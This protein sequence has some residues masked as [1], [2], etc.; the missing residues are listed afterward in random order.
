MPSGIFSTYKVA[1]VSAIAVNLAGFSGELV[2]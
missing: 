1:G 2:A